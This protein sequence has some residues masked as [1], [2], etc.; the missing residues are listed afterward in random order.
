[1]NALAKLVRGRVL[2]GK[3][4]LTSTV[5]LRLSVVLAV[6]ARALVDVA[7]KLRTFGTSR[8]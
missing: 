7:P 3:L 2:S 1:M 8:R 4:R 5:A 6:E